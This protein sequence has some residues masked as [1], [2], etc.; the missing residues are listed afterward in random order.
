MGNN[1][2][3]TA[4]LVGGFIAVAYLWTAWGHGTEQTQA[5]WQPEPTS[6]AFSV[7]EKQIQEQA[8]RLRRL[9]EMQ[10]MPETIFRQ[11]SASVGLIVGDYIWTDRT[12]RR[13]LHYVGFDE[14]GAPRRDQDGRELVSFAADG[15]VVVREF[16]GTGFLIDPTH[17]LTSGFILSPW[18]ADPLLDESVNPELIPSIRTLH[19]YFPGLTEALNIKIDRAAESGDAVVCTLQKTSV[20]ARSLSLSHD[21][22]AQTGEA[23]LLLGYPGGVELL[24]TRV[25]EDVRRE[26]YRFGRPGPDEMA[27]LLA[28]KGYIQPIAIE[29]RVSGQND[30]RIFFETLDNFGAAGGPLINSSGRVMAIS[31][32]IHPAYP[33]FNMGLSVAPMSS[34]IAGAISDA[35]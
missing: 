28:Q 19:I 4:C 10:R 22:K 24:L 29:T 23:I 32:A 2:F 3:R 16:Q 15:P 30:D 17:V 34:W 25:P 20:S 21:E 1:G 7:L 11:A 13:P 33:S 8:E 35:Q 5:S 18:A 27:E 6:Q 14:T 9:E 26:I 12:G 31:H